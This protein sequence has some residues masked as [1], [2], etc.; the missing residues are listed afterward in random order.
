MALPTGLNR[1]RSAL[2]FLVDE[3]VPGTI[4]SQTSGTPSTSNSPTLPATSDAFGLVSV[5]VIGQ[6]GNYSDTSEIGPELITTDRVLNYMEYSTFD[7]EYYAKPGGVV[8]STDAASGST[9]GMTIGVSGTTVTLTKSGV[10]NF[11]SGSIYAIGDTIL[12][13]GASPSNTAGAAS[14]DGLQR[15]TAVG[16]NTV[17]Y[18]AKASSPTVSGSASV[19]IV[20]KTLTLPK[21][22]KILSRCFGG[23]KFMSTAH[24][25]YNSGDGN[26]TGCSATNST[27]VS[28]FLKNTIQTLSVHSR[29][30]TDDSVQMYTAGGALPTSFSVTMAKDGAVTYS[31][32]FQSNR[33]Y[34]SGT[35]EVSTASDITFGANEDEVLTLTSPI[36]HG[37]DSAPNASDVFYTQTVASAFKAGS[38]VKLVVKANGTSIV[39]GQNSNAA[40]TTDFESGDYE[41]KS[42]SGA[43]VT[44]S[45]SPAINTSYGSGSGIKAGATV[46]LVPS[47]PTVTNL[48]TSVIDQRKVQVFIADA[49]KDSVGS[50]FLLDYNPTVADVADAD[51]FASGTSATTSHLFHE[52][53]SLDVT[54]VNFEFDRSITT[55]GLTE[56]TGEEFPSANY[57][58]NEPTITGSLTLLLRPK[59]FQLMNSLREEPR[60]AIAV[61]VGNVAGKI[62]E[63]GAA[64]AF[65]EVPTPA[66]ADGATQIDIPFTVIRGDQGETADANKFFVRYR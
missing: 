35:A 34:Y 3:V 15:I 32:G 65:F 61:R 20:K 48:S 10:S 28:Y 46:F 52:K 62:I 53:N 59:D 29:Q 17:Q 43:T 2:V 44:I 55:P 33:V 1:S 16:T 58:I 6:Q 37:K 26:T 22:D 8:S 56:M 7:L 45:G 23:S 31:S 19:N 25:G 36:R 4:E 66:D 63:I 60:R 38:R 21:E 39:G 12:V 13:S 27:C 50:D 30:F 41:V 5:P 51:I 11:I 18:T 54:S 57:I 40:I 14:C 42:I 49:F 24:D 64:S 47:L 9:T